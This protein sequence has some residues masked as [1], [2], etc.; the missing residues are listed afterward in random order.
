MGVVGVGLGA[1]GL[2]LASFAGASGIPARGLSLARPGIQ[3]YTVRSLMGEDVAATLDAV[4]EIGYAEVEFA[5]YFGRSPEE[6]RGWLDGAGL[7]APAA[8]VGLLEL[9]E[10]GLAEAVHAAV[11]IGHRWLVLPWIPE[12]MRTR[13]GYRGVADM[14][15]RA[16]AV[17]AEAGIRVAYHNHEFEFETLPGSP[18]AEPETGMSVLLDH[19]DPAMVDLQIDF[20]WARVAGVDAMAFLGLHPGRFRLCHV[21]DQSADGDMVSVG[22]GE[23][24]WGVLLAR[25]A[26]AGVSHYIVEHDHPE[27]PLASARRSYEYL[28]GLAAEPNR[29]AG[30]RRMYGDIA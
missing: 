12:H 4:A 8:H 22:D 16:A 1:R 27:D 3:L 26:E 15:N 24:D 5:G 19:S 10:T 20:Y 14:L 30:T 21:K 11:T 18:S 13:D 25:A 23:I 28:T 17:T 2:S 7:A 29:G 9:E 6:L